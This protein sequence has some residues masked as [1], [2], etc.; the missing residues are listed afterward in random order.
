[1][2]RDCHSD[3]SRQPRGSSN[4]KHGFLAT[5]GVDKPKTRGRTGLG[6]VVLMTDELLTNL[7]EDD[8][9]DFMEDL[10][11]DSFQPFQYQPEADVHPP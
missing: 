7:G 5:L 4:T 1:M 8:E 3:D 2:E 9:D 11:I 6:P 10:N